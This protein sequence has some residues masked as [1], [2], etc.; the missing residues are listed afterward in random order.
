MENWKIIEEIFIIYIINR[1]LIIL[2]FLYKQLNGLLNNSLF[3]YL[4]I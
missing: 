2:N 1:I 3:L 4:I